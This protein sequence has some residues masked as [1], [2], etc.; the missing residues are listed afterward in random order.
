MMKCLPLPVLAVIGCMMPARGAAPDGFQKVVRQ[1]DSVR[2]ETESGATQLS[3]KNGA[4]SGGGVEVKCSRH[5]SNLGVDLYAPKAVVKYVTLRWNGG[6]P[7]GWKYLGDAWERAYGDLQWLPV[8]SNRTMPWYFLS[9]DGRVTH[10]YGVMTQPAAMCSWQ[11][12]TTGITLTADVRCG[13]AGVLLGERRLTVC[14]IASRKGRA[15][16]TPFAAAHAFCQQMCPKP[17]LPKQPVY[18]FNDWYCDYGNNSAESV[19]YYA[20]FVSRLAPAGG[21]RPFMVIDDG[22]QPGGGSGGGGPWDHG[23]GKFPSMTQLASDIRAA[24]AR[25]GIWTRLLKAQD[26][27]PESWR[28]AGKP[29]VLDIS[30]PEVREYVKETVARFRTWGFDLIKHDYST[31]DISDAWGRTAGA[32]PDATWAFADRTRTTAEILLDHYR[33]IREGAGDGVV[34]GCNTVSHLAAGIFEAQRIGDDTSGNDWDRTRKMGVNS[35]AFRAPQHGA[36]YAADADCVGLTKA[37]AIPW[38]LTRQWLALVSKSGTPLFISFKK[39]SLTP[40]Q[41]TEV[42]RALAIAARPQPL[43]EPLDWFNNLRPTRWKLL[44]REAVYHWDE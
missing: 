28:I 13:G 5:I 22:W 1:P 4:W 11:V 29:N 26:G 41:E 14:T 37:G 30:K 7:A 8:D 40:E 32:A 16:E 20:A 35:L 42:A 38:E 27:Q 3:L 12:D 43:C 18:G 10:A 17:R 31:F 44:G 15:G 19:R 24:G 36:F 25:P 23:N 6:P 21:N 33:S 39:G 34:I 9:S 2:V